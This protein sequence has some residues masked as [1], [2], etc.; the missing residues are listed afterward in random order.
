MGNSGSLLNSFCVVCV[1]VCLLLELAVFGSL[2]GNQQENYPFWSKCLDTTLLL[3]WCSLLHSII[4]SFVFAQRHVWHA[5]HALKGLWRLY[6]VLYL[7]D[8]PNK[9]TG[10]YCKYA[11]HSPLIY[12]GFIYQLGSHV[13]HTKPHVSQ[14]RGTMSLFLTNRQVFP[15]LSPALAT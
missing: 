2:T 7:H 1:C 3:C 13:C 5:N 15:G 4:L 6:S 8:R 10:G 11:V 14:H 12:Q 9:K